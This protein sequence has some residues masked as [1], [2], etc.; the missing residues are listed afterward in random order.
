M[1]P[2]AG[3]CL[4]VILI[5]FGL[6]VVGKCSSSDRSSYRSPGLSTS[7]SSADRQRLIML[8]GIAADEIVSG[9]RVPLDLSARISRLRKRC[10]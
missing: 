1:K 2:V 5:F 8:Q 10:G 7:C 3:G 6:A 9:G 4:V